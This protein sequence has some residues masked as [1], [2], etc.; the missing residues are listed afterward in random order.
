MTAD[1]QPSYALELENVRFSYER[2]QNNIIDIPSWKI[3]AGEKVFLFGPSGSG[4][5]TLL[6]LLSGIML[7]Q[8]GN[9]SY[10]GIFFNQLSSMERDQFRADHIGV[11]FQQFNLIP[12]LN[13]Q[14]NIKLAAHFTTHQRHTTEETL[15]HIFK[16]L[17]LTS[18]LLSHRAD[19]LSVGQQQRVA[20]ARALINRPSILIADEPTSALDSNMRNDFIQ[21]LLDCAYDFQTTVI[22]VSHDESLTQHFSSQ[23]QLSQLNQA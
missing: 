8:H 18:D 20:I 9:I 2:D 10:N 17:S 4:K 5:S 15:D 16:R 21:L 12:Y 7:P 23:V 3:H 19:Q 22:F 1:N 11:I 14:E 13:I 6:N